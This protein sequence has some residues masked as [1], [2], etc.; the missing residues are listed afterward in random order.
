MNLRL[1]K[2][3]DPTDFRNCCSMFTSINV[4]PL[5]I[6]EAFLCIYRDTKDFIKFF[7]D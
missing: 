3:K 6:A 7:Q 2:S 5:P 4:G 1:M